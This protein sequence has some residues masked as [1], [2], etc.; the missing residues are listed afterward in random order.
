MNRTAG[1]LLLIA[2]TLAVAF[3]AKP[4]QEGAV[5]AV[6]APRGEAQAPAAPRAGGGLEPA[7]LAERLAARALGEPG[8]NPMR[9]APPRPAEA[10]R[11][12]RAQAEARPQP[13]FPFRFGGYVRVAGEPARLVLLEDGRAHVVRAGDVLEPFRI[14]A[15]GADAL[16]ATHLPSGELLQLSYAGLLP[17]AQAA[18]ERIEA[19]PANEALERARAAGPGPMAENR[20]REPESAPAAT[21]RREPAGGI[22]APASG[23]RPPAP[24]AQPK[25]GG[26]V[27]TPPAPGGG[28]VMTPPSPGGGMSMQRGVAGAGM[29]MVP[30]GSGAAG[31]QAPPPQ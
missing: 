29:V 9:G 23:V 10:P 2:A 14:E 13:R 21:R 19:P 8:A 7:A 16:R 12:A 15:F 18:H 24:Q 20:E 3:V 11:A 30:P 6:P 31:P 28:M 27:M 17:E 25:A 5:G 22:A 1:F 4:P 26:M